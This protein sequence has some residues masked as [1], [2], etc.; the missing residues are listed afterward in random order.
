MHPVGRAW[1]MLW[2]THVLK[3]GPCP[4]QFTP[5]HTGKNNF[6]KAIWVSVCVYDTCVRMCTRCDVG[7]RVPIGQKTDFAW[8]S[9]S[10]HFYVGSGESNLV[11]PQVCVLSASYW[12][13]FQFFFHTEFSWPRT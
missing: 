6:K 13:V 12:P 9:S 1:Q 2:P 11:G 5:F 7:V 10:V 3:Q 8:V 4:L